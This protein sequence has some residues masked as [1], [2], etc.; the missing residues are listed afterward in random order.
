M[1]RDTGQRNRR[2]GH[3]SDLLARLTGAEAG[4][5]VN[6]NA[7][8]VYLTL[9]TFAWG[10]REVVVSRGE[11]VEI[12]GSFRIPNVMERAGVT[13][14]EV[15]ATNRTRIADY[16]A[17]AG[18]DTGLLMKVHT[19]NYRVEGFTEEVTAAELAELGR[20][21]ELPTAFDLGSGLLDP[22]GAAPL[23]SALGDEAAPV[24]RGGAAAST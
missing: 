15:G 19:S 8:A 3:L 5:V 13:L 9:S 23:P 16:R 17:A 4:I 22:E 21:L 10:G 7:A 24:R 11:L 6:N 1:D 14:R 20:E 18:P 2:D 12:G